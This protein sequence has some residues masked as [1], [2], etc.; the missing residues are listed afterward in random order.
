MRRFLVILTCVL[1]LMPASAHSGGTDSQGGHY[2]R[3]TGEY[4]FHHG[5]PAHQHENG[6]C[7]YAF[8]DQTGRNSGTPST[9][10][11]GTKHSTTVSPTPSAPAPAKEQSKDSWVSWVIV[12][13]VLT[14]W[15]GPVV[16]ATVAA[17]CSIPSQLLAAR[18]RRKEQRL[19][20]QAAQE[21]FQKEREEFFS[22]Y[23]GRSLD[24]LVPPATLGAFIGEDGLPC[25]PG[26]GKWGS[27]YTVFVTGTKSPV[28]HRTSVCG[29]ACG[30]PV[31]LVRVG[32]RRPCSRCYRHTPVPDLTWYYERKKLLDRCRYYDVYPFEE[33]E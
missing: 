8:D 21:R 1:L 24:E 13:V 15:L 25:G 14:F 3:S 31:N 26:L 20:E 9:G 10:S 16:I 6:V 23:Q 18:R 17:L 5:Y 30:F 4:H 22:T 19:K 33:Q 29:T 7:P 12:G 28:F 27:E 11:S 32:H 2:N